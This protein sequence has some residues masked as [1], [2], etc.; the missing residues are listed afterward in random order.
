MSTRLSA[1]SRIIATASLLQR[2]HWSAVIQDESHAERRS[3]CHQGTKIRARDASSS[4]IT[5][6]AASRTTDH[7]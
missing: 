5:E 4:T 3:S 6:L 7:V 1:R 2:R